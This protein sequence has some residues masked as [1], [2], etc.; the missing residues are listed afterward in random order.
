MRVTKEMIDAA[1]RAEYDYYQR[2][3]AAGSGRFIGTPDQVIKAMLEA[4]LKTLEPSPEPEM[5]PG[6][7][8]AAPA[9]PRLQRRVV[10]AYAPRRKR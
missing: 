8:N 9:K 10:T 3:R 5:E 1:R 2:G 6:P 7:T 4:A